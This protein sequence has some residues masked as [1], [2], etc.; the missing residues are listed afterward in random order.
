MHLTL[1]HR[2]VTWVQRRAAGCTLWS[3]AC[4]PPCPSC[5]A[6]CRVRPRGALLGLHSSCCCA[7]AARVCWTGPCC[8]AA[9]GVS[10][11]AAG[12]AIPVAA[13]QLPCYRHIPPLFSAPRLPEEAHGPG[14]AHRRLPHPLWLLDGRRPR[15]QPQRHRKGRLLLQLFS[16]ASFLAE[17]S[18]WSGATLQPPAMAPWR[19]LTLSSSQSTPHA[20][21]PCPALHP[22]HLCTDHSGCGHAV[23]LDGR[24]P[25]PQ[26]GGRMHLQFH[27][28]CRAKL[29]QC[30]ESCTCRR[31]ALVGLHAQCSSERSIQCS[32]RT[33]KL[34]APVPS[35]P[36]VGC[37]Q[38]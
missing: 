37:A 18:S 16:A 36:L 31:C 17:L 13:A 19:L 2:L 28:A 29:L 15:R 3:R 14:A 22:S 12:P 32:P 26:G 27:V 5:C 20:H 34:G 21:L 30:S 24:R 1:L 9:M 11:P 6:A 33:I 25:V 7:L 38:I 8:L 10:T 23:P 4:G 35:A